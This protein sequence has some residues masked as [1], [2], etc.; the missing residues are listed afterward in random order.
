MSLDHLHP[1]AGQHAIQSAVFA[2]DF[3]NELDIGEISAVRTEATK[4]VGDFPL[5][6]VAAAN[7]FHNASWFS[8]RTAAL[9]KCRN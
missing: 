9:F 1:F 7:D 2:L 6:S 8:G 3:A 5:Q 4:L